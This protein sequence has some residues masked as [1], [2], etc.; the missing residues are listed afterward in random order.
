MC[1]LVT[2]NQFFAF[3]MGSIVMVMFKELLQ[4]VCGS[5]T[6]YEQCWT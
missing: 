1:M 5:C 3:D 2:M 4:D 6:Y